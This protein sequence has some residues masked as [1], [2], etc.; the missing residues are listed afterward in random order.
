MTAMRPGKGPLWTF[1]HGTVRS[2]SLLFHHD[3]CVGSLESYS[4]APFSSLIAVSKDR[5]TAAAKYENANYNFCRSGLG[6]A[7]GNIKKKRKK[8]LL[9]TYS[10]YS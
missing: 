6:N 2:E 8:A 7:R 4:L 9:F 10:L 3:S 5:F 1:L